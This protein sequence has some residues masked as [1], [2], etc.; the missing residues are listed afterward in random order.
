MRR[1][2]RGYT[3]T[4]GAWDLAHP[5]RYLAHNGEIN[6]VQGNQYWMQAR[7]GTMQS[8]LFGDDLQ[9]LY[10]ICRDGASDSARFD[11]A[12]EFLHLAGRELPEAVLMM[13]PEAWENQPDMDPDARAFYEYH[14]FEGVVLVEGAGIRIHVRL[15]LPR[16]RD[17]HQHRFRQLAA[18]EVQELERVVEARR[19]RSPVAADRIE[20]LQIVAEERRLHRALAGLH[21]VLV[22]LDGVDLAVVRQVAEGVREV[23][24]T[25]RVR[26]APVSPTHVILCNC[27]IMK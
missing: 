11:N 22:A 10:P 15:V 9:K 6:T 5:F 3:N 23:P 25:H 20:L 2:N 26:V 12:L 1:G 7:E 21:P 4:M 27:V 19:V 17:H 18:G 24:R 8:A 13:I 14:S 16:L